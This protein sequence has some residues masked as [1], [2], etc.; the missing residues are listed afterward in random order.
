MVRF[1]NGPNIPPLQNHP[2]WEDEWW[3][4]CNWREYFFGDWTCP[5]TCP[6]RNST[7][8]PF[9]PLLGTST[10]R[11]GEQ[12]QKPS[13]VPM[14]SFAYSNGVKSMEAFGWLS[15]LFSWLNL[16]VW[17]HL[18]IFPTGNCQ[19]EQNRGSWLANRGKW[20]VT[21]A[22]PTLQEGD[23]DKDD[24]RKVLNLISKWL[25][26]LTRGN[27][28]T[29]LDYYGTYRPRYALP[30]TMCHQYFRATYK[31]LDFSRT[32]TA[33]LASFGTWIS[34]DW[35]GLCEIQTNLF[36]VAST[37]S[38]IIVHPF[39]NMASWVPERPPVRDLIALGQD[40]P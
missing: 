32:L 31:P 23:C 10:G 14:A 7:C 16:L 20:L 34:W 39:S 21:L 36:A 24:S 8:W 17:W 28:L 35:L 33:D 38:T 19:S 15:A 4:T 3:F 12:R 25:A 5:T 29:E 30:F 6:T 13:A 26:S 22:Q 2:W 1:I 18:N 9:P 40:S 11:P 27:V 37:V